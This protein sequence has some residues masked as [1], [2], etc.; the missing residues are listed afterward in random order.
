MWMNVIVPCL[1]IKQSTKL[2]AINQINF[3]GFI[4]PQA[5][6]TVYHRS[7]IQINQHHMR[8]PLQIIHSFY[9]MVLLFSIHQL[10]LFGAIERQTFITLARHIKWL[11]PFRLFCSGTERCRF[12]QLSTIISLPVITS[13]CAFNKLV[14]FQQVLL[15]KFDKDYGGHFATWRTLHALQCGCSVG[16]LIT[17][18]HQLMYGCYIP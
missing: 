11:F 4:K 8:L 12:L 3:I 13:S 10:S 2:K 7:N 9:F 18:F 14:T 16:H 15:S 17:L 1:R 5:S 6:K